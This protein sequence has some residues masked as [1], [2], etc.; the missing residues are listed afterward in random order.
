MAN[1]LEFKMN[2]NY[3][4]WNK[5][6]IYE[7]SNQQP[8]LSSFKTNN[9]KCENMEC[10]NMFYQTTAGLAADLHK[11]LDI[12]ESPTQKRI[13]ITGSILKQVRSSHHLSKPCRNRIL[14]FKNQN[15]SEW[16]HQRVVITK[17]YNFYW[18]LF[19]FMLTYIPNNLNIH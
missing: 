13:T 16:C 15:Q 5:P 6:I 8:T 9:K 19:K 10:E 18:S 2:W 4:R 3:A 11:K 17:L 1:W 7:M 12:E 14:N